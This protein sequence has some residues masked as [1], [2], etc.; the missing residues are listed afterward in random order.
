MDTDFDSI[1]EESKFLTD[2]YEKQKAEEFIGKR[3]EQVIKTMELLG[4]EMDRQ[5]RYEVFDWI[6]E[7]G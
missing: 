5:R 6:Y 3:T 1:Y 7:E 4:V 2:Y